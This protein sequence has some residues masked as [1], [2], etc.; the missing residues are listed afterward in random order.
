MAESRGQPPVSPTTRPGRA[1][2][3]PPGA[4]ARTWEGRPVPLKVTCG[5]RRR[6]SAGPMP[7]TR[8][9]PSNPPKEPLALRSSTIRRARAGP[10]PGKPSISSSPARSRS[11]GAEKPEVS[12]SFPFAFFFGVRS[13][14]DLS[15]LPVF[16]RFRFSSASARFVSPMC[17]SSAAI[18][19]V[20]A[21]TSP[22]PT[23]RTAAPVR[24]TAP[25]KRIAFRSP[26]VGM[27][28]TCP[29]R[30]GRPTPFRFPP[31]PRASGSAS[32]RRRP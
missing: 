13:T 19:S 9:S 14:F 24:M 3:A 15:C 12:P 6:S 2:P 31:V 30:H 27:S 11:T 10:I 20:S 17:C 7:G 8:S 22:T 1:A 5:A 32:A 23:I 28:P 4:G 29:R 25:R 16:F 26:G 18:R 21:S